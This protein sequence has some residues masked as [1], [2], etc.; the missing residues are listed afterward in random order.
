M[1]PRLRD[2]DR[3]LGTAERSI[4]LLERC[5]PRNACGELRRLLDR[6]SRGHP[7]APAFRYAAPV[8]LSPVQMALETLAET[9][10]QAG[11]WGRL[12]AQ[13][14]RELLHE[15]SVV[16]AIDTP[17]FRQRAAHRFALVTGP[18][19]AQAQQWARQWCACVAP[20]E[21][22]STHC[23]DDERDGSS[24]ISVLR[25]AVG[26]H[27]LPFRVAV[28]AELPSAAATGEGVI[29]VRA[30]FRCS[31]QD[32]RRI[33]LHE[34]L[35]HAF[36][37]HRAQRELLGLF[38]VGTAGSAE[39]EE[40]RALLLEQRSGLFDERRRVELG[41]RHLAALAVRAGADFFETVRML[42][43]L[44]A[45]LAQALE[46]AARCHR[47][48]G[49]AREAVYLPALARVKDCLQAD[50]ELEGWMER[51]RISLAAASLLRGLGDPPE[52]LPL[53]DAA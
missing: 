34:L 33:A 27:R 24:L 30:T 11:P 31:V 35:G 51:G 23:S 46:I 12:Y 20:A 4:A 17:A 37:R 40:G 22:S 32:A 29:L 19:L 7:T 8:D 28:S 43:T 44:G 13:R 9:A 50:P 26:R 47:G 45:P 2:L 5:R 41:R 21:P 52:Y 49:L 3:L 18:H 10:D 48:G 39:D 36:P 25:R 42:S 15:A 16:G 14:A 1:T 38:R 6:W 53:P